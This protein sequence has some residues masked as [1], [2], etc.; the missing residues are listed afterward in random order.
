MER[1]PKRI[2]VVDDE[3][4]VV[5]YLEAVLRDNGYEVLATTDGTEALRLVRSER[6][7]LVCLDIAMPAPT[8]V[9]IYRELRDDPELRAIPVV[10]ITGVIQQFRDFIHHRKRV[11]PPDGY[12]AKPFAV[13]EL[14]ETLQRLLPSPIDA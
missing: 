10:M 3:A 8:G 6:P 5:S 2:L 11:P 14:L 1:K 7:D 4:D 9:K 13:E 12:I